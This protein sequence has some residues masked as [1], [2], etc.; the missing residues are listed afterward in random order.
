M[1]YPK[2]LHIDH[3]DYPFLPERVKLQNVE[4]LCTTLN[5]R[6]KY[7]LHLKNIQQA[8]QNGL[9]VT[10]VHRILKFF[11]SDWMASYINLNNSR[12]EMAQTK[13]L[14]DLCKLMNNSVF[15]KTAEDVMRRIK[16]HQ[17]RRMLEQLEQFR[18]CWK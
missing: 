2:E 13:T 17:F 14:K 8:I 6:E 3:N 9:K 7:V 15:E 18:E 12:R 1:E 4:K 5:S 16:V 11:Q 10:K